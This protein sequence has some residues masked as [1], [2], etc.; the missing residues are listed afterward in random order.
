MRRFFLAQE[1]ERKAKETKNM[2][3]YKK[4]C[5]SAVWK[6][7]FLSATSG[8]VCDLWTVTDGLDINVYYFGEAKTH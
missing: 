8:A 4:K 7:C 1:L 3:E 5:G 2:D 6:D